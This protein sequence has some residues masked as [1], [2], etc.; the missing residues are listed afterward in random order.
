[1]DPDALPVIVFFV[2]GTI[3]TLASL[4]LNNARKIVEARHRSPE[5]NNDEVNALRHEVAHLHDK[6]NDI[7]LQLEF[8]KGNQPAELSE[9]VT[10]PEFT[11]LS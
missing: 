1:M 4:V 10:S 11:K 2:C 8:N 9:R 7:Q 6:M 5:I 3:I